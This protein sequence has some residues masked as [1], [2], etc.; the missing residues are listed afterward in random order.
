MF[1]LPILR[2]LPFPSALSKSNFYLVFPRNV[3]VPARP[4][5]LLTRRFAGAP[6]G[7]LSSM[8][9]FS[10]PALSPLL[11][12]NNPIIFLMAAN[13]EPDKIIAR[14]HGQSSRV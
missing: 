10:I 5:V 8:I 6:L 7:Q 11:A 13:P 4:A 9:S 12:I 2:R 3:F 14:R 1:R